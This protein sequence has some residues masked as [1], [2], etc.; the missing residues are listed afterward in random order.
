M[1]KIIPFEDGRKDDDNLICLKPLEFRRGDW[2][3]GQVIQCL[4]QEAEKYQAHRRQALVGGHRHL[5]FVPEHF[6]LAGGSDYTVLGLYRW[7]RESL[8]TRELYRLAGLM[9]C[10]VNSTSP[11]LRTDLLRSL[12]KTIMDLRRRLN[13]SW[14]G[15]SNQFLLPLHPHLYERARFFDKISHTHTLKDLYAVVDQETTVQFD[16]LAAEYV[17]YLPQQLVDREG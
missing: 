6:K 15:G 9:E 8:Q 3:K 5:S 12:Y 1:A 13:M 11:V 16:Q 10:V 2:L 14:L 4:R 7:R 17:F